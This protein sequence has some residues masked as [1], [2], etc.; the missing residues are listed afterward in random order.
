MWDTRPS[1]YKR[2]WQGSKYE[3]AKLEA[4]LMVG[5]RKESIHNGSKVK[6]KAVKRW[7]AT[8]HRSKYAY[9]QIILEIDSE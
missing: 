1:V 6:I 9:E 5:Y 3:E 7:E 8:E 4:S 2:T